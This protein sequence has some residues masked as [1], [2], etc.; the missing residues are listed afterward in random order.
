MKENGRVFYFWLGL[1]RKSIH[2]SSGVTMAE[3]W[4]FSP[5]LF[6]V[7]AIVA[8]SGCEPCRGPRG[9][10]QPLM[11]VIPKQKSIYRVFGNQLI[12]SILIF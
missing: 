11:E 5:V 6:F 8:R 12:T 9:G 10:L 1:G 2:R 7:G 3:S 4:L